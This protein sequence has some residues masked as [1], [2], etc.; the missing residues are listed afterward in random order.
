MCNDCYTKSVDI[1]EESVSDVAFNN[2]FLDMTPNASNKRKNRKI[3][4]HRN[5]KLLYSVL[6][7]INTKG[8][9]LHDSTY[10]G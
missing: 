8:Q 3:G 6:H 1:L 7:I 4:L 10:M 9:L 2:G 5:D